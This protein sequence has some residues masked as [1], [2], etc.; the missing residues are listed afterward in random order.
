MKSR[1][2]CRQLMRLRLPGPLP[3]KDKDAML[4]NAVDQLGRG[5]VSKVSQVCAIESGVTGQ[6]LRQIEA[7]RDPSLEPWLYCVTVGGNDL[8]RLAIGKRGNVLIEDLGDQGSLISR[9][10][11]GPLRVA[12]ND[13]QGQSD[14][15]EGSRGGPAQRPKSTE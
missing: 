10:P 7:E 4:A 12:L 6:A 1:T 8:Q 9:Y 15:K 3:E 13:Y 14:K 11:L 5:L 2:F